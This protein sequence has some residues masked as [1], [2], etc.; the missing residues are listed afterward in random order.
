MCWKMGVCRCSAERG[1]PPARGVRCC[2]WQMADATSPALAVGQ[3][4]D[5]TSPAQAA[6]L[7]SRRLREAAAAR[8]AQALQESEG[9][10]RLT[11]VLLPRGEQLPTARPSQNGHRKMGDEYTAAHEPVVGPPGTNEGAPSLLPRPAVTES[12]S[13]Q[14]S[15]PPPL[16]PTLQP[17][18]PRQRPLST[19]AALNS[20]LNL[21]NS[22]ATRRS[23]ARAPPAPL[24]ALEHETDPTVVGSKNIQHPVLH[25]FDPDKAQEVLRYGDSISLVPEGFNSLVAYAGSE[26][27][28]PWCE[29]L[30]ER[31]GLPP[32]LRECQWRL[33]PPRHYVEAKKFQKFLKNNPDWDEGKKLKMPETPGKGDGERLQKLALHFVH[34][35]KLFTNKP[36]AEQE[37]GIKVIQHVMQNISFIPELTYPPSLLP[38]R[39]DDYEALGPSFLSP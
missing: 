27:G 30:S 23:H 24:N 37:A 34:H 7:K 19:V 17:P 4:A 31:V 12:G 21:P 13:S 16:P 18:P 1:R 38:H 32:N 39:Q 6:I 10:E 5:I 8:R 20:Q 9:P 2:P 3:M 33:Q 29:I 11:D 14:L 22:A 26:D 15:P 25:G 35:N 28:L 36:K